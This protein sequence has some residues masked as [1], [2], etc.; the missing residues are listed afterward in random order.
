MNDLVNM[1]GYTEYMHSSM[2]NKE[3]ERYVE[4]GNSNYNVLACIIGNNLE[5]FDN[6]S[7]IIGEYVGKFAVVKLYDK[8][9]FEPRYSKFKNFLTRN[10]YLDPIKTKKMEFQRAGVYLGASLATE[11]TAKLASRGIVNYFNEKSAYEQFYQIYSLLYN[12]V[13]DDNTQNNQMMKIELNKI[14]NSFPLSSKNKQ[15]L[16]NEFINTNTRQLDELNLSFINSASQEVRENIAYLLYSLSC[17]KYKDDEVGATENLKKYYSILGFNNAYADEL[18]R[19]HSNA[20]LNIIDDQHTMCV[21]AQQIVKKMFIDFPKINLQDTVIKASELA[22]YDP[23]SFRRKRV[24]AT[25]IKVAQNGVRITMESLIEKNPELSFLGIIEGLSCFN[26]GD[27]LKEIAQ[28]RIY[29]WTADN[30]LTDELIRL[31]EKNNNNN[32]VDIKNNILLH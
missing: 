10:I 17:V 27:D 13:Q 7:E 8:Q 29:G 26:L 23:Y 2:R 4:L 32:K 28:N 24:K 19:E 5:L 22:K 14:R 16:Q 30:K 15:K 21:I 11:I 6:Y 31:A 12:F 18:L 25:T 3:E 9:Y 1:V 20:Y